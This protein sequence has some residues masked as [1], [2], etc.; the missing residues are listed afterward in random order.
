MK[1]ETPAEQ[2]KRLGPLFYSDLPC[3][4]REVPPAV[5]PRPINDPHPAILFADHV[6]SR[7]YVECLQQN[8]KLNLCCRHVEEEGHMAQWF[9]SPSADVTE[10]GNTVPDILVITCGGCGRKHTRFVVGEGKRH[11]IEVR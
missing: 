8:Q 4:E 2:R 5:K 7:K 11:V 9:A 6:E 1:V 3:P 10:K